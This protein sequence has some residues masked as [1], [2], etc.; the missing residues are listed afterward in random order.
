[1]CVYILHKGSHWLRFIVEP[2]VATG[3]RTIGFLYAVNR[4]AS[5]I[6]AT[7]EIHYTLFIK[8]QAIVSLFRCFVFCASV[9][10]LILSFFYHCCFCCIKQIQE[11]YCFAH[12]RMFVFF[13]CNHRNVHVDARIQR[14]VLGPGKSTDVAHVGAVSAGRCRSGRCPGRFSAAESIRSPPKAKR[15]DPVNR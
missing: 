3:A 1:M 11:P 6:H 14:P 13:F 9:Q 10:L 2:D 5:R 4:S 12:R 7:K 15:F 8:R